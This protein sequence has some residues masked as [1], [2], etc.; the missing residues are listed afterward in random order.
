[1]LI[2][3][4]GREIYYLR[5]SVTDRCNFRCTY[6][7]PSDGIE[8]K[9]H[10]QML[11]YEDIGKIAQEAG[12]MGF[13]KIRLTGGEPLVKKNIERCV[14]LIKETGYYR[15]ICMTT[16]GSLLTFEKA[17]ALKAG[18]LDRIT[19]SLDTL[20]SD[21]F[22]QITR[23]GV[24]ADVFRGIDAAQTAGF[25]NTKVNMVITNETKPDEIEKMRSFCQSKGV[26]LQL[27]HRFTLSDREDISINEIAAQRPP[28]CS[29]C[30]RIRITADGFVKSC[31][32]SDNEEKIDLNDIESSL[33]FA[34]QHKP[35]NGVACSNR[36][37][38]QIG[39]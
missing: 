4:F 36:S 16:N 2:D 31:L 18:G 3:S 26:H 29:R 8:F 6:C 33:R 32:F 22:T 20:D 27:I 14:A 19:V 23:G 17:V 9:N 30:N 1:M 15:D 25:A 39:G 13:Y 34:V 21:T 24:I 38:S 28:K 11:R 35:E 5:I 10:D 7:M 12:K 37:M